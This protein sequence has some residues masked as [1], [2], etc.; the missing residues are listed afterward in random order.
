M[1]I[2]DLTAHQLAEMMEKG[3]ITCQEITGAVLARIRQVDEDI[4]AYVTVT[5]EEALAAAQAVDQRRKDGEKLPPLAGIPLGLKDNI[6]TRGVRTTCSSRM[7]ENFIPP[8]S[9]TIVEKLNNCGAVVTG[10]LNMDEFAMGSSTEFSAFFPTHN[11]W[12]L[13]CVP[14]G[15]SGGP[16]AAVAAGEAIFALGSDTGG[17][18]RQPASFCGIVGMKPTYGLVSRSGVVPFASSLDQVG[19]LTKDVRDCALVLNVI[20]G[21]DPRDTATVSVDIPDYTTYLTGNIKGKRIGVPKELSGD[22]LDPRVAEVFKKA[23]EKLEELGAIVDECSFP[24][25]ASAVPAYHI[26][27][28]AEASS[29]L[30][31]FDGVRYGYRSVP[32][33]GAEYDLEEMYMKTRGEGFGPEVKRRIMMGTYVLSSGCYEKYYLKALK[34]RTLIRNEYQRLFQEYDLLVTPTSPDLPFPQ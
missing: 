29:N 17:S 32:E 7:L 27:A 4:R 1:E 26:I 16:A 30:A 14:G 8:Y 11:P 23:L 18:A 24:H 31:R 10:K 21:H 3:K 28:P 33:E 5:E 6:C 2:F 34:V 22:G 19:T 13:E 15:S 20:A 25:A 12:D 9:A